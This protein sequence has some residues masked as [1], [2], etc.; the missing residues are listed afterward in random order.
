MTTIL[1]FATFTLL[2]L[3]MAGR[4]FSA[5]APVNLVAGVGP[6]GSSVSWSGYSAISVISGPAVFPVTSSTTVLYMAFTQG[7]QADISNMVL[8]TTAARNSTITAVTPVKLGGVSNPSINLANT[9]VCPV[10]PVSATNPCIIRLDP[11][12][13][14]LT[15]ASDYYFVPYFT[16]NDNNNA[17]IGLS[18]PLFPNSG[19]TGYYRSGDETQLTVGQSLP[20]GNNGNAYGLVAVMSN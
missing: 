9:A 18:Q 7:S 19:L 8:Y 17:Q 12:T 20:S 16:A 2:L 10:Q 14:Q 4:S 5:S 3:V 13:L 11:I 15:S 1:R 6:V